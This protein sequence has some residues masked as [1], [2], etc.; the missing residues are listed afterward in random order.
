MLFGSLQ[1]TSCYAINHAPNFANASLARKL[2]LP[3]F[4][5]MPIASAFPNPR[6]AIIFSHFSIKATHL[7]TRH[8]LSP[9]TFMPRMMSSSWMLFGTFALSNCRIKVNV[10]HA[11]NFSHVGTVMIRHMTLG[12]RM[13]ASNTWRLFTISHTPIQLSAASSASLRTFSA[14]VN[15]RRGS[16]S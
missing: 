14:T 5:H 3:K 4:R 12:S 8:I 9:A 16:R 7:P 15:T 6:N 2:S 10:D 11:S 1:P 13:Q